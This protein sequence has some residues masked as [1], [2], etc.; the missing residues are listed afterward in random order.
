M[1]A[2]ESSEDEAE[3]A[4]FNQ[5]VQAF[6]YYR[7]HSLLQVQRIESNMRILGSQWARLPEASR[8]A[9][10][11]PA[12][13]TAVE[14]NSELLHALTTHAVF[15]NSDRSREPPPD[16]PIAAL[17]SEFN[18]GKVRSTLRQF[19]REWSAEGAAERE[20]TF[21]LLLKELEARLPVPSPGS[22]RPA[23]RVL[24][25]GAGLGR[26]CYEVAMRGYEAQGNEWSYFMLLGSNFI[27]NR[28]PDL[29]PFTIQPW[30]HQQSNVL[31]T[32]DQLRTV[33]VPD[34]VPTRRPPPNG[35]LSMCAGDFVEVYGEQK[36]EWD[37][38]LT[39]FFID[40]A[41]NILEYIATMA[42]CLKPGGVWINLGPLL[43]HFE[44][45]DESSI[46]LSME[47][48]IALVESHDFDIVR[49]EDG[50]PCYYT[51]NNRSMMRMTY[52]AT[53]FTAVKRETSEVK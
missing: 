42:A 48:V 25:P 27:L 22:D 35:S 46:E 44:E 51:S 13:L 9:T 12:L 30:A 18:M 1:A 15:A 19:V 31:A 26:L 14:A 6:R 33:S 40:T 52:F 32:E 5:I 36:C 16:G 7:E 37:C 17:P 49:R 38:V 45:M 53:S 47:E 41:K 3:A 50:I 23:P 21:G 28:P 8:P 29:P 39:C 24:V 20:G 2:H 10:K 43:Y 11:I 34:V 4:H